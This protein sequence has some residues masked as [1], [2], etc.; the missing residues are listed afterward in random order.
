[1]RTKV[2]YVK[3]QDFAF[4]L[5]Q[6]QQDID[7]IKRH[8]NFHEP[9]GECGTVTPLTTPKIV[10][11]MEGGIINDVLS[12]H[13]VDAV[14]IDYDTEGSEPDEIRKIPQGDGTT[15]KAYVRDLE[16]STSILRTKELWDA[17]LK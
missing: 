2:R 17:A 7:N 3:C 15:E 14:M 4:A 9:C 6:I 5:Q 8:I 12:T 1:M 13:D 16:P 11:V 10:I